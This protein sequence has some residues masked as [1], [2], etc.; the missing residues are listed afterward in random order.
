MLYSEEEIILKQEAAEAKRR[1]DAV[2]TYLGHLILH[3]DKFRE[4]LAAMLDGLDAEESAAMMTT[5]RERLEIYMAPLIDNPFLSLFRD[6]LPQAKVDEF[7]ELEMDVP[8][9]AEVLTRVMKSNPHLI[10]YKDAEL[11]LRARK[12]DV[13]ELFIRL[14]DKIP[15]DELTAEHAWNLREAEREKKRP[16]V[17]EAPAPKL[18]GNQ[19]PAKDHLKENMTDV[20]RAALALEELAGD[21]KV[22]EEERKATR[23][24]FKED[25]KRRKRQAQ[26]RNTAQAEPTPEEVEAEEAAARASSYEPSTPR[27]GDSSIEEF[28]KEMADYLAKKNDASLMTTDLY[29]QR[30]FWKGNPNVNPVPEPEPEPEQLP[31]SKSKQRWRGAAAKI[32]EAEREFHG[33]A[34]SKGGSGKHGRRGKSSSYPSSSSKNR[35]KSTEMA[36]GNGGDDGSG[37]DERGGGRRRGGARGDEEGK[38]DEEEE[39][40]E[41]EEANGRRG[42]GKTKGRGS[43]SKQGPR[44]VGLDEYDNA[45]WSK[46]RG[47]T[48]LTFAVDE[49]VDAKRYQIKGAGAAGAAGATGSASPGVAAGKDTRELLPTKRDPKSNWFSHTFGEGALG[50]SCAQQGKESKDH[51]VV[52]RAVEPGS[53]AAGCGIAAGTMLRAVQGEEC[54]GWTLGQVVNRMI[55]IGR[56]VTLTFEVTSDDKEKAEGA[57]FTTGPSSRLSSKARSVNGDGGATT[58]IEDAKALKQ[59]G[60]AAAKAIEERA[61][62]SISKKGGKASVFR[63]QKEAARLAE[64]A[65]AQK[66]AE[67]KAQKEK[68]RKRKKRQEEESELT[69]AE[70][71]VLASEYRTNDDYSA[72]GRLWKAV[73]NVEGCP[74]YGK[75]KRWVIE[76]QALEEVDKQA[77]KEMEKARKELAEA[78]MALQR[79]ASVKTLG[80]KKQ[81]AAVE[82]VM[83]AEAKVL[84]LEA[85][86]KELHQ[87]PPGFDE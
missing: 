20:Q 42:D 70:I 86:D 71:L 32:V 26:E 74:E 82:A 49:A 48:R 50:L 73:K 12:D 5:V 21:A 64:E 13:E 28:E 11:S 39:E 36:E 3:D 57:D 53:L 23:K 85:K 40:E 81:K 55:E 35:R 77:E 76:Q 61:A 52:V 31:V 6:K 30:S 27:R 63:E 43:K 75:F 15:F 29:F 44:V 19:Q 45:V 69:P 9:L 47:T 58:A 51:E 14:W 2:C 79:N 62:S 25:Q 4:M 84:A 38:E 22:S 8:R 67:K 10:F 72:V 1:E 34:P 18:K 54:N 46:G 16:K 17:E 87:P 83:A 7:L 60:E 59:R 66:A 37:S 56:P 41:E 65:K 33:R 24:Q 68:I 80:G 78:L